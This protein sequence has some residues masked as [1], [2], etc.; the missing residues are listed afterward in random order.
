MKT[1]N[2]PYILQ[3]LT[4][5][6]FF[7]S[8][9]PIAKF[10]LDDISPIFLAAFLY[11]GSGSGVTLTRWLNQAKVKEKEA[12][13]KFDDVKWLAGAIISGGILAPIILMISL[14]NTSGST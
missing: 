1:N 11:L 9:A 7:G 5:A 6:I 4:A 12:G 8:S 10:L 2:L 13:I 3:A 14:Q